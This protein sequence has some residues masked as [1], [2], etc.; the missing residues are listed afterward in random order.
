MSEKVELHNAI[1][2]ADIE[3]TMFEQYK[4]YV[5][6]TD[7]ISQRR[8]A[9]NNFYIAANVALLTIASWFKENFGLYVFLISGIGIIMALLWFFSIRSHRQLNKGKFEVIHEIE[10]K[11]PLNLFA[12]EWS[13]LKE[14]KSFNT[15]WSFSHVEKY[16]PIIFGILYLALALWKY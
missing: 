11:L 4:I 13:A 12:Y 7:R 2:D 8:I 15:Y 16:I 9:T 1:S 10:R 6:L 14:G 5:E 3:K